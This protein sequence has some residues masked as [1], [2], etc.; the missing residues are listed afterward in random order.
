MLWLPGG[1]VVD[2]VECPTWYKDVYPTGHKKQQDRT[3][4]VE[5]YEWMEPDAVPELGTRPG[6]NQ[7]SVPNVLMSHATNEEELAVY[8]WKGFEDKFE[9]LYR[10][11]GGSSLACTLFHAFHN[12]VTTA[13]TLGE[14]RAEMIRLARSHRASAFDAH[15]INWLLADIVDCKE[16]IVLSMTLTVRMQNPKSDREAELIKELASDPEVLD[17]FLKMVNN[18]DSRELLRA[19]L[20]PT[21]KETGSKTPGKTDADAKQS[22]RRAI[23]S[24]VSR[25]PDVVMAF[26]FA[27]IGGVVGPFRRLTVLRIIDY[28]LGRKDKPDAHF[29]KL[30]G[31]FQSRPSLMNGDRSSFSNEWRSLLDAVQ[32]LRAPNGEEATKNMFYSDEK[33]KTRKLIQEIKQLK[34]PKEKIA[35]LKDHKE[36]F[37]HST[38]GVRKQIIKELGAFKKEDVDKLDEDLIVPILELVPEC[39]ILQELVLNM[40]I[41]GGSGKETA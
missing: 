27:Q 24:V 17:Q 7:K 31:V 39:E 36:L 30:E 5:L 40:M 21:Q 9:N 12:A 22:R 25:L 37:L 3:A 33:A 41:T 20:R 1:V 18:I 34:S 4:V 23:M 32:F 8:L 16:R 10:K 19:I 38:S 15:F 26:R 13:R 2:C 14:W 28:Y 35:M 29:K 6:A 11:C